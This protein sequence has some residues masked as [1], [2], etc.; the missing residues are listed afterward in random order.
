MTKPDDP[1]TAIERH[2]MRALDVALTGKGL[3]QGEAEMIAG[4]SKGTLSLW[5]RGKRMP[6]ALRFAEVATRLGLD[7][8]ALMND[9]LRRAT[10]AGLLD[11]VE[12][13]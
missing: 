10:E 13:L 8:G 6:S 7:P 9:G 1:N 2:F 3:N 4:L 5:M 12:R 11:D